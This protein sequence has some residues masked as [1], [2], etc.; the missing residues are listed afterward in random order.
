MTAD[1]KIVVTILQEKE[2]VHIDEINSKS[3]LTSSA[4][5]AGI[6]SLE[7]QN[8]ILSLP[9]KLYQLA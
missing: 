4:V 2:K 9:G 3:G 8:V 7:L 1:E 5:A 6:L